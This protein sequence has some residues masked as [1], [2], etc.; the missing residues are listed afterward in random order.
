MWDALKPARAVRVPGARRDAPLRRRGARAGHAVGGRARRAVRA[1]G[2]CRACA[3]PTNGSTRRSRR[4]SAAIGEG[5][6]AVAA[7]RPR[8]CGR[9]TASMATRPSSDPASDP[10]SSGFSAPDR[11]RPPP[12]E[13]AVVCRARR[14]PRRPSAA[15]GTIPGSSTCCPGSS[16]PH[17]KVLIRRRAMDDRRPRPPP[18][19][20]RAD[21]QLAPAGEPR[22]ARPAAP[23]VRCA[24]DARRGRAR[25]PRREARGRPMSAFRLERLA[26]GG[27][28]D[29]AELLHE[30]DRAP[31]TKRRS[32]RAS[33]R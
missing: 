16:V 15:T 17:K 29:A 21:P 22:R 27:D 30:L 8:R 4:S 12:G 25:E 19:T 3:A 33:A 1:E 7:P 6:P 23:R 18:G 24:T 28:A 14:P 11:D 13:L 31:S 10:A 5:Y 26:A 9:S 20:A 32:S 2:T